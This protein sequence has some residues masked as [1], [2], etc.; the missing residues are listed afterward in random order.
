MALSQTERTRKYQEKCDA[1]MLRPP[2]EVGQQIRQAAADAGQ[3]V[4]AYILEAVRE[5]MKKEK[6]GD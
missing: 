3:S 6:S 2:K 5:R 4:S 1:I